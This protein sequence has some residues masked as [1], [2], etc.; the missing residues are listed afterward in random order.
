[1]LILIGDDGVEDTSSPAMQAAELLKTQLPME[2]EVVIAPMNN[3]KKADWTQFDKI[4]IIMGGDQ[5]E[6]PK[7][8]AR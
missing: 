5:A 3:Y 2:K 8:G 7:S 6:V 4:V 1:M